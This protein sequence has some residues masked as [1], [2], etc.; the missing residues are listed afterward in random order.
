MLATRAS[1]ARSASRL[2]RN[3]A[4]VVD[5]SGVKVAAV[6]NGEPTSAVKYMSDAVHRARGADDSHQSTSKRSF[7]G[8]LREAE[9]YGGVL[10]TSLLR[11][12]LALAK[13]AEFPHGDDGLGLLG[14]QIEKRTLDTDEFH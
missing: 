9:L 3:Y 1:A 10:S 13:T 5:T 11:E 12:H 8:T 14:E 6:D 4:S 2:T 7:L